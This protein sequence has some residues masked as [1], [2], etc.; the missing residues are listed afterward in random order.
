MALTESRRNLLLKQYE[1]AEAYAAQLRSSLQ[2]AVTTLAV[3]ILASVPLQLLRLDEAGLPT[4]A[5]GIIT[6]TIGVWIIATNFY[7]TVLTYNSLQ[8]DL[9]AIR[10]E[11]ELEEEDVGIWHM[12]YGLSGAQGV[13][14]VNWLHAYCG[15]RRP[16][17]FLY[18]GVAF[19]A[20][21]SIGLIAIVSLA[22][23]SLS[24]SVPW[25][26]MAGLLVGFGNF[27]LQSL[28][29]KSLVRQT[30]EPFKKLLRDYGFLEKLAEA[31]DSR[32]G[33]PAAEP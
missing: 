3:S 12:W 18:F 19:T 5:L 16:T 2:R 33:A 32:P 28:A 30:S 20:A 10:I 4:Y 8:N 23:F 9:N 25:A 27:G 15:L 31:A 24:G 22:T 14:D 21:A 13:P 7:I 1:F 29:M 11:V 17:S 6:A 26:G